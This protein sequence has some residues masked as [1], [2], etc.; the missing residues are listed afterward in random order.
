MDNSI[1]N[2]MAATPISSVLVLS[3]DG[4]RRLVAYAL[5]FQLIGRLDVLAAD[6]AA[7]QRHKLP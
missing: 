1:E 5:L 4:A 7:R 6:D 2:L 3:D